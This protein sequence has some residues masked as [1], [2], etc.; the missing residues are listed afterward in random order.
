MKCYPPTF[1][2][3]RSSFLQ[4]LDISVIKNHTHATSNLNPPMLPV[5]LYRAYLFMLNFLRI[6]KIAVGHVLHEMWGLKGSWPWLTESLVSVE[7]KRV[8]S[9]A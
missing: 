1:M 6:A 3:C 4:R 2:C 5:V 8:I 9:R 7:R